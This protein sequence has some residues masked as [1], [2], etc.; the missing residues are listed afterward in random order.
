MLAEIRW[1]LRRLRKFTLPNG[2][3]VYIVAAEVTGVTRAVLSITRRPCD[4]RLAEGRTQVQETREAIAKRCAGRFENW[5]FIW[6]YHSCI[7]NNAGI[8]ASC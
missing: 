5:K 4:Q 7:G 1:A 6:I 2:A 8:A 3:P